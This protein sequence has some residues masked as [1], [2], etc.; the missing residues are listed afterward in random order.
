MPQY[1]IQHSNEA[2]IQPQE[3]ELVQIELKRRKS[4]GR[5]YIGGSVFGSRI[6]CGDCGSFFGSKVWNSTDKYRRRIWQCNNKFKGE[7]HCATP[8]LTGE[9]IKARFLA[10]YNSLLT[11]R[12]AILDDCRTMLNALTDCTAIDAELAE[13]LREA[14]VITELTRRCIEE[15]AS[16]AQ[17][18]EEYTERYRGYE[19]RYETVKRKV[20]RLQEQ[21]TARREEADRIG[22]FMFELHENDTPLTEFDNKLWLA[23]VDK[24]TVKEDG[25]LIFRFRNG[26][27][28]VG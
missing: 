22:A 3:W 28:V 6:V 16:H 27:E 14:E 26:R 15:N 19:E 21:R 10:A 9:D 17:S 11:D 5:R 1:L 13:L 25:R 2:I 20:E 18:Q 8:H 24:V 23:V 7:P 12:D 4:L